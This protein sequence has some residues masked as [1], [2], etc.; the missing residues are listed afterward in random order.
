MKDF[1]DIYYIFKK[2]LM[3]KYVFSCPFP[4]FTAIGVVAY[5]TVT[6]HDVLV[7]LHLCSWSVE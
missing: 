7:I 1:F 5:H 6:N 4:V 2:H 3:D